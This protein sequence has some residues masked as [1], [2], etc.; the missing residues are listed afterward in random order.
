MKIKLIA[1]AFCVLLA[2][3]ASMQNFVGTFTEE[4]SPED[5][6]YLGRAVAANILGR[7]NLWTGNPALTNYLNY[8]CQALVINSSKP[9]IY[10]GYH[11]A[12]LDTNEIN[13]FATPGGHIFLTRGLIASASSE[14]ALAGVIAHE[15]AHIQL[16]HGIRAIRADRRNEIIASA[17]LAIATPVA[18]GVENVAGR[19]AGVI[20]PVYEVEG[21][22]DIFSLSVDDIVDTMLTGYS[23]AWEYE[24]DAAALNIL[25]SAGY[26][27]RGLLEILEGLKTAQDNNP[28]GFNSTH[29]S[30]EERITRA[31]RAMRRHHEVED[32]SNMRV[33][34]FQAQRR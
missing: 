8:I 12:I 25:A 1:F 26:N 21:L 22:D 18:R 30:P 34:R 19:V 33:Q 32:T 3:C 16:Q 10:N 24:A 29:P 5:E 11:V 9:E 2:G 7:Y 28:G 6:Y 14:D 4:I 23:Q 20:A 15:I 31:E 17:G 13:A 27:P